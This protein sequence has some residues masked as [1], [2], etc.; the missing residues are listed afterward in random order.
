MFYETNFSSN[1]LEND[2]NFFGFLSQCGREEN[3]RRFSKVFQENS[4]F[5]N[6]A[7]LKSVLFKKILAK[8]VDPKI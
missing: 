8:G 1:I 7:M 3:L 5:G 6:V 2:W 4:K